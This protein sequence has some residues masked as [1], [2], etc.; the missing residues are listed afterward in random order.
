VVLYD[1]Q[2]YGI[3]KFLVA[4]SA[5]SSKGTTRDVQ[6]KI[7]ANNKMLFGRGLGS[8]GV[9]VVAGVLL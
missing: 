9:V 3:Q 1:L 8:S 7:T 4:L 2:R 6:L 5:H